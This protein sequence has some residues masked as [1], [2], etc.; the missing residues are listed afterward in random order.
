MKIVVSGVV[1]RQRC[2]RLSLL[3]L[4]GQKMKPLCIAVVNELNI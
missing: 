4:R 3:D 1:F 2:V